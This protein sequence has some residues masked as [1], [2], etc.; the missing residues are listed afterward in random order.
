MT[1]ANKSSTKFD[2][3][4]TYNKCRDE[5]SCEEEVHLVSNKTGTQI[6]HDKFKIL[7]HRRILLGICLSFALCFMFMIFH[8]ENLRYFKR[9]KV[10]PVPD[11]V[12]ELYPDWLESTPHDQ[13]AYNSRYDAYSPFENESLAVKKTYLSQILT[14]TYKVSNDHDNKI[15][16]LVLTASM[17]IQRRQ[18][19][20]AH[21]IN[22]YKKYNLTFKFV[23]GNTPSEYR[24]IIKHENDTYGDLLILE[25]VPD[26]KDIARTIKLFETFKYIEEKLPVYK[27]IAKIDTDCFVNI[28]GFMNNYFNETVQEFE[29]AAIGAIVRR[30]RLEWIQ[31]GF[32]AY[33]YK[34]ML[35]INKMYSKVRR[36]VYEEDFQMGWYLNDAQ[37][38]YTK[39]EVKQGHQA[40][41]FY[42]DF[43][44]VFNDTIRVHE[45][46]KE[47]DYVNVANCFDE[48][49]INHSHISLMRE[50]GWK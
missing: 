47:R 26:T 16:V 32:M 27:Y 28:A 19:M 44:D 21:Q 45:L 9:K 33:S 3:K 12:L 30:G 49:G 18:I 36:T 25:D 2:V 1:A 13:S 11:P 24:Q 29:L 6:I 7:P 37:V 40:Y 38:N 17:D 22:P 31:G 10:S 42:Y 23:L 50:T 34:L 48:N 4:Q 15:L 5:A 20:R 14:T 43:Q 41:D 46:K 8:S 39:V 35:F